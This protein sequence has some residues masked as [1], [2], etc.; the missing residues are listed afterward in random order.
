MTGVD[1]PPRARVVRIGRKT[2]AINV[3]VLFLTTLQSYY[4]Y[5]L[6]AALFTLVGAGLLFLVGIPRARPERVLLGL[7]VLFSLFYGFY[8][9]VDL[10]DRG[11]ASA[12]L[13]CPFLLMTILGTYWAYRNRQ[14]FLIR[15]LRGVI[16]AHLF[17]FLLQVAVWILTRHYIDFLEPIVG[18]S[19]RYTSLKGLSIGFLRIPRFCG[20]FNEPG[21]F[22]VYVFLLMA[23]DYLM[24]RRVTALSMLAALCICFTF[25]LFGVVLV[26]SFALIALYD[27]RRF[28][29]CILVLIAML[30]VYWGVNTSI[31]ERMASDYAGVEDRKEAV[32]MALEPA[33]FLRG[34]PEHRLDG[35]ITNGNGMFVATIL[36]GG[37]LEL[38]LLLLAVVFCTRKNEAVPALLVTAVMMTKIKLTYPLFWMFLTIVLIERT[39]EAPPLRSHGRYKAA[40]KSFWNALQFR[41]HGIHKESC[42][43]HWLPRP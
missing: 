26:T 18:E 3:F 41:H 28:G 25:S 27:L 11:R 16:V 15:V 14:H 2:Y 30:I 39:R 10:F 43:K 36:H 40:R 32:I 19:Q 23:T 5:N 42:S 21:T 12:L 24:S 34:A 1:Y 6:G 31:R 9:V 8:I 17:F 35:I 4:F 22:S 29:D 38:I 33:V 13:S 7:A 37:I 20:L